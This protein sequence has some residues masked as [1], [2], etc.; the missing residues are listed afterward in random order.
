MWGMQ[1]GAHVLVPGVHSWVLC[2]PVPDTQNMCEQQPHATVLILC[3]SVVCLQTGV[4]AD[5][6]ASSC[7]NQQRVPY[8]TYHAVCGVKGF[9]GCCCASLYRSQGSAPVL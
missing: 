7:R 3:S 5:W 1:P 6:C 2:L 9:M 4:P 8:A